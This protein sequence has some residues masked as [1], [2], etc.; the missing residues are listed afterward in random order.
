MKSFAALAVALAAVVSFLLGLV[1]AGGAPSGAR[2]GV[3]APAALAP[4]ALSISMAP[5]VRQAGAG[6]DF[7]DVAAQ[8]NGTVVNVDA[9]ARD[10][11][12]R[13]TPQRF[14]RDLADDQGVP[15]EGSGSGF[16]IDAAGYILTNHHV[17]EGADR[18]TVTLSD[19]RALRASVVGIDPAIDVA[20]LHVDTDHPLPAAPLGDSSA[21][22]V[23]EWVCA[24]GNPMGYV[25]SVTVGVVS[26]LGRKLFDQS[27]DAFIQTDAAI[28]FGNSGGPLINAAGQVVGMATAVSSQASSIGFAIPI[29]QIL[30]V[31]PQL[32]E[33]G[34]VA[35]G[36]A[37]VLLTAATPGLREALSLD[38]DRGALIQ[39]VPEGTPA[40]RAGLRPYD[41]ITAIDDRPVADD[42]TLIRE[43]AAR[44][45]GTIVRLAVW[46]DGSSRTVT[47]KLTERPLPPTVR[48]ASMPGG[49]R[50]VLSPEQGPLGLTVRDLDA[51]TIRRF[52]LPDTLKG[53]QV[54][55]IDS[56]GPARVARVR[57]GHIILEVNRQKVATV[58]DFQRIVAGLRAGSVVALFIFDPLTHERA[59]HAVTLDPA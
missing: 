19:G 8:L 34:R 40:A 9:V 38:V 58:T 57:R 33:R 56:T 24:I 18:V 10:E 44:V 45:P 13:Q 46:R 59:V 12:T 51:P 42:Q 25:H 1:V 3:L 14:R 39:D 37:G 54:I 29:N 21:V 22:R 26:F 23:G 27:L 2:R 36:Y 7:S 17:I 43:I 11:R 16:I 32:R 28:S 52:A 53:V 49:V 47:V 48:P 35:R 6:V 55:D 5:A 41:V 4:A 20:L 31:L 50:P 15:R 30:D